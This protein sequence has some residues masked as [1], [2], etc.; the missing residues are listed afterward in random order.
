MKLKQAGEKTYY[1]EHDTNIGVYKTGKD[2]VCLIDTGSKGD[3]EKID[4]I[5]TGQGW[6]IDYIINTHTHID[7]LGGN[8]YLMK[9]YGIPA[10]CTEYDMAFAHYSDLESAY[11]SG[12]HPC[13]KLRKIFYHPGMIGF[14]SVEHSDLEGISWTYLPGHTF[15][16][17]GVRTSDGVWFLADSY[18]NKA[19][20][21]K[22]RFG[23][24]YD[25]GGYLDTLEY[26]KTLDGS[27][28]IPAHGIAETDIT[29]IADLNRDNVEKMLESIRYIC[30]EYMSIDNILKALFEELGMRCTVAN[31]ALLSSTAKSYLTYLQDRDQLDCKFIDNVMM[32]K[33]KTA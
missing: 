11:M 31:H 6:S 25:V 23:Y 1:I 14:R 10:Y 12:G 7:H 27:L 18:L 24:L 33:T 17:I 13:R 28:Y 22:R 19:Y 26:I 15:G 16:M 30:S 8:E 32:W 20:M 5:I 21:E 3:G 2:R 4:E 9:K 29:E